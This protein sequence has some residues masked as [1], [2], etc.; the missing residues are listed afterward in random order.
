MC[1]RTVADAPAFLNDFIDRMPRTSS[2]YR[3]HQADAA[4]IKRMPRTSSE[5]REDAGFLHAS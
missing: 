2:G 5:C 1:E 3:E 4:N